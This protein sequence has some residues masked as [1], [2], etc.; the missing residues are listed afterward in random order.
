MSNSLVRLYLGSVLRV[1]DEEPHFA[2]RM[3]K[4]YT[5][6][7]TRDPTRASLARRLFSEHVSC[8]NMLCNL[9]PYEKTTAIFL[10][11]MKQGNIVVRLPRVQM[12]ASPPTS[13]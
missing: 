1:R 10:S 7:A 6:S 2:L 3:H 8:K 5:S 13:S 9:K 4:S 12:L 11:I